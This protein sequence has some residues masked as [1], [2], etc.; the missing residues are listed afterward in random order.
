MAGSLFVLRWIAKCAGR[1]A[2]G[3]AL[4]GVLVLAVH[5]SCVDDGGSGAPGF[6][7]A[8]WFDNHTAAISISYDAVPDPSQPVDTFVQSLGM[9]IG[10][11]VTTQRFLDEL[12]AWVEHDLAPLVP[13]VV[14][15]VIGSKVPAH[16]TEYLLSL[17]AQGFGYFGHG[18]WHVNHDAL[19][20]E[21]AYDSFRLCFEA[22]ERMGL[23]PVAY[24][25]PRGNAENEETRRALADAGFLA[26][27]LAST[28]S[29]DYPPYIAPGDAAA[30]ADW[31]YLPALQME[32]SDFQQCGHCINDTDELIPIL[33]EALEQTAWIIPVYHNIGRSSGFGPYRWEH[34]QSDMRAIAARDFWV[35]SMNEVTLYMRER[36][37]AEV[38]MTIV[39]QDGAIASIQ[40]VLSDGLDNQRFDQPLTLIF[41]PPADWAG[42]PV[43]VTQNNRLVDWIFLGDG[44][45]IVSL[46]PNEQPYTFQPWRAPTHIQPM[47]DG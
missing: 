34:F 25:Y 42:L 14:P 32:A 21:Q 37:Q 31:F 20:Y 24:A 4:L 5:A 9:I 40:A 18:H 43:R 23:T 36:E 35:A 29:D 28:P 44:P 6:V 33:D 3:G 1:R 47:D 22:M 11:E 45:A 10:Y 17:A 8:K 46:P 41:T 27:R 16:I 2:A 38:T 7:V 19:T 39:E 30:P 15:G 12:P 13:D 26:G